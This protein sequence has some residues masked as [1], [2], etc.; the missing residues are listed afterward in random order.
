MVS[1]VILVVVRLDVNGS[2]PQHNR[3]TRYERK[4]SSNHRASDLLARDRTA[5][6]GPQLGRVA[7]YHD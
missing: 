6:N 3:M 7:E 2:K 1:V 4:E 5:S